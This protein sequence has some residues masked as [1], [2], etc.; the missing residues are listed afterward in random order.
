MTTPTINQLLGELSVDIDSESFIEEITQTELPPAV[1]TFAGRYDEE[2]GTR[3]AFGWKWFYR[4]LDYFTLETVPE[5][6]IEEIHTIKTLLTMF[7]VILDDLAEE[8]T[9]RATFEQ[10]RTIP[11]SVEPTESPTGLNQQA[12]SLAEDIWSAVSDRLA[13]LPRYSEFITLLAYDLR[14]SIT[15]MDYSLLVNESPAVAT[16]TGTRHYGPHNMCFFPY[17]DIDLMASPSVVWADVAPLRELYWTAQQMGWIGNGVT[18]WEREVHE[19][20][21]SSG[22]VVA[23][24]RDGLITPEQLRTNPEATIAA[25][26]ASEIEATLIERWHTLH[27]DLRDVE[28]TATSVDLDRVADRMVTVMAFHLASEGYK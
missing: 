28:E 22:V 16:R 25:I 15:A 10:A 27:S 6:R 1:A 26:E 14:Q 21:V 2:I 24:L 11:F 19:G 17:I 18:T 20:D 5:N 3:D 12:L 9:D 7:I 13:E 23:A 8:D 4:I